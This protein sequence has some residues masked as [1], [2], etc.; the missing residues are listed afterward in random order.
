MG[1]MLSTFPFVGAIRPKGLASRRESPLL[2]FAQ[3]NLP[4]GEIIAHHLTYGIES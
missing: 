4:K 1:T 3:K 2:I